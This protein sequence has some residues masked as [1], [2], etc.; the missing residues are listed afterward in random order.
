[1][2]NDASYTN[3]TFRVVDGRLITAVDEDAVRKAAENIRAAGLKNIAI[4]GTYSPIDSVHHQE[5]HVRDILRS[6][7]GNVNITLSRDVAGIGFIER[8]N[9]TILNATILPFA[10]RTIAQFKQSL[11]G[12]DIT[13]NL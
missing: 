10:K 4:L 5:E 13:A 3:L 12:L 2:N 8:E 11:K 6:Y 7:L 9:A 1:M